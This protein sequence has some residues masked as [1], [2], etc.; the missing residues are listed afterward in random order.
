MFGTARL[1]SISISSAPHPIPSV[2]YCLRTLEAIVKKAR[3]EPENGRLDTL[4]CADFNRY[5][6]LWGG[7][8]PVRAREE[9]GE[10]ERIVDSI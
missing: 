6:V 2:P 8:H 10:G 9:R 1:A 7:Y 3:H 5:H 4:I